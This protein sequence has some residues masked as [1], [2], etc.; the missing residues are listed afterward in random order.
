MSSFRL[1]P[2]G[3]DDADSV[4]ALVAA[5]D[6]AVLGSTDFSAAELREEWRLIDPSDRFVAIDGDARIVGYG[7]IEESP[8][9]GRTDGYVHPEHFGRGVGS[10]LVTELER[11]LAGRGATRVQN[12]ALMADGRAHELLRAHGYAEIRRFW[13]M[14]IE[15][16]AEPAQPRWPEGLN[17]ASFDV[18]DGEA[19]HAALETAFADHWQHHPDTFEKWRK[20]HVESEGFSPELWAVVRA[21]GEIVAGTICLPDR[22]GAA[23]ISRLFTRSDWRRR[24]VGEALLQEAFGR[25]WR[26]GKRTVGLGVDAQSDTG[27]N[28][29]YERAGMRVHWGAAV[30]EKVLDGADNQAPQ[31]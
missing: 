24:G 18:D 10:L 2:A 17:V 12:A 22:M 30:F 6:V 7:T 9:H 28:R 31:R 26:A 4:A 3:A 8:L 23:W 25:F 29:L 1:R 5:L 11:K 14:R 27:A 19:F 13:Q 15:L 21:N 20:E 16:N